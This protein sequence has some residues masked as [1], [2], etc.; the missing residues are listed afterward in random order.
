MSNRDLNPH[1]PAKAAMWLFGHRYATSGLGSMAFWDS[2]PDGEKRLCR[3]MVVD[4]D[5]SRPELMQEGRK[6]K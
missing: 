1:K 5:R 4:I 6:K 3:E 2:L